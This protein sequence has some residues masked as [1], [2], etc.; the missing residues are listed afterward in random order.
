MNSRSRDVRSRVGILCVGVALVA[1]VSGCGAGSDETASTDPSN[2]ASGPL[3]QLL[4][5]D[6]SA[7][8]ARAQQLEVEQ[9]VVQCMKADGWTYEAVDYSAGSDNLYQAEYEQQMAD[10][11]AYGE[12]YG[13]GV[14]RNYELGLEQEQAGG[15]TFDDP[16]AEYVN[17]LSTDEMESYQVSLYGDQMSGEAEPNEDGSLPM[18]ALEDQG[19]YGKAQLEVYGDSPFTN[20][21]LSA[22]LDEL[23]QDFEDDPAFDDANAAW[24]ACMAEID[25]SYEWESPDDVTTELFD[26][27][28]QA[29]G[30]PPMSEMD[31]MAATEATVMDGDPISD[32]PEMPEVDEA[33]I[34][35]L[36]RD[37]LQLW[38]HDQQCQQEADIAGVR[39]DLE[40][41]LADQLLEEFPE[42]GDQ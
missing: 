29:Q 23:G 1:G 26:R 4:G 20:P 37:E 17:T 28:S 22:R 8:D 27:L 25:S 24:A 31:D 19:C 9:F 40:Q 3:A 41:R 18:P 7:A 13:Y 6:M 2:P 21:D 12:K 35:E 14:V 15:G 32:T 16:N 36:R 11:V 34:D 39:R 5:Y 42:L 30:Y 10:P 33:A 38:G